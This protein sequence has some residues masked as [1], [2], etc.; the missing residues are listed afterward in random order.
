MPA[1]T[2]PKCDGDGYLDSGDVLGGTVTCDRCKGE[3]EV[4]D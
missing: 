1:R 3:G 2:C 4:W